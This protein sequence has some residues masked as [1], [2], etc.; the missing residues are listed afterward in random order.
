MYFHPTE[1]IHQSKELGLVK[2]PVTEAIHPRC[3]AE[4]E[5]ITLLTQT[6][7]PYTGKFYQIPLMGITM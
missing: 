2:T 7:K 4:N 3:S 6:L 1:A 5:A